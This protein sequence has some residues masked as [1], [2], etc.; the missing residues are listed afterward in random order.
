MSLMAFDAL[1]L[2]CF[3]ARSWCVVKLRAATGKLCREKDEL[4]VQEKA[5]EKQKYIP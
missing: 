5:E 1:L 3:N 2:G 4:N